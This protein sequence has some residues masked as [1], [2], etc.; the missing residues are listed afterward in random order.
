LLTH[1][2]MIIRQKESWN[3]ITTNLQSTA[4]TKKKSQKNV[5]SSAR[6][7]LKNNFSIELLPV[8]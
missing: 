3:R 7:L 2:G 4:L 1:I 5:N 8:L 6:R